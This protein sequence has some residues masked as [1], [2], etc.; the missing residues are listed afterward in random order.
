MD[1]VPPQKNAPRL[2]HP[3]LPHP[4]LADR[5]CLLDPEQTRH[6]RKVL[7]ARE[8]SVVE[9]F[10]GEGSLA[11]AVIAGFDGSR[12]LCRVEHLEQHDPPKP[13]ITVAAA[14]P[15][16]TRPDDMVEQL[17]QVGADRFV[18]LHTDRSVVD[19]RPQKLER[20]QRQAVEAAKQCGRLH[21]MEIAEPCDMAA[22]LAEPTD[23]RLIAST[24]GAPLALTEPLRAAVSVQVLIGPEGGWSER[25]LAAA[26]TAG[27]QRWVVGPMVMRIET[28][29]PVTVALLR[30]LVMSAPAGR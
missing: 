15:K 10:D 24:G 13:I 19:P 1:T 7:R 28:A 11:R 23:L 21:V 4:R 9:L 29:A 20:L 26:E 14:V 5:P 3:E 2:Y 17:S 22:A 25:E 12:A 16:G 27:A 30:Y 8:G 18:P 6:L